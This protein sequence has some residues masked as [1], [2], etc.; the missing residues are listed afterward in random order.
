L[1]PSLFSRYSVYDVCP[2]PSA[3]QGTKSVWKRK[4]QYVEIASGN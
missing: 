3:Q 2:C 4:C 1:K